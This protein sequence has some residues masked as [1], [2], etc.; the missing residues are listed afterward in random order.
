MNADSLRRENRI[1]L[2]VLETGRDWQ[3]ALDN[4]YRVLSSSFEVAVSYQYAT[5]IHISPSA[6]PEDLWPLKDLQFLLKA[7]ACYEQSLTAIMPGARK[8]ASWAVNNFGLPNLHPNTETPITESW[9]RL[10]G[11][12]LFLQRLTK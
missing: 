12:R 8:D 5:H 1:G 11:L 7:A 4:V 6:Q 10:M 9:T 2:Q 3:K